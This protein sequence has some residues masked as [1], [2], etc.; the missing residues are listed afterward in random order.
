ML[1]YPELSILDF[2][3]VK[4]IGCRT[5]LS[6]VSSDIPSSSTFILKN[7]AASSCFIIL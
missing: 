1:L 7:F 6:Y 2:I 5:S 3:V 4:S